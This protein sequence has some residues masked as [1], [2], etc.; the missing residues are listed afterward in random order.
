MPYVDQLVIKFIA[1]DQ[2]R[3]DTFKAGG[4]NLIYTN[5][6]ELAAQVAQGGG[7]G[8]SLALSGGPC[9]YFNLERAPANDLRFR[10]AVY[11]G[12]NLAQ[13]TK[14]LHGDLIQPLDSLFVPNSPIYD[15]SQL[16]PG[17]DPVKAQQLFDAIYASNGNQDIAFPLTVLNQSLYVNQ[18]QFIQAS[19]NQFNHVK[20]TLDVQSVQTEIANVNQRNYQVA[21]FS[22]SFNDPDPKWVNTFVSTASPSPT[23]W[24]NSAFDA[25]IAD[26]KSTLDANKRVADFREALR[27]FYTD[28]PALFIEHGY[29]YALGSQ[30]LQNV[31]LTGQDVLLYDRMWIKSH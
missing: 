14:T 27:Q 17:Y 4:G 11:A 5:V 29:K 10:Q 22:S 13:M 15:K 26:A 3:V 31:T 1:D 12:I 28:M 7:H 8:M 21:M 9:I 23:A 19:L 20:V 30:A 25:A 18:A 16:Q 24:K 2:Q 6:P